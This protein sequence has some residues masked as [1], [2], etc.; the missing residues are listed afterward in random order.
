MLVLVVNDN[1]C[2]YEALVDRPKSS[3]N[4]LNQAKDICSSWPPTA[5]KLF[6]VLELPGLLAHLLWYRSTPIPGKDKGKTLLH[7][8]AI[9]L[10]PPKHQPGGS[11]YLSRFKHGH[12]EG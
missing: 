12:L 4:A 7:L 11:G 6:M 1:S 9:F 5:S 3:L 8:E 2:T 10:E